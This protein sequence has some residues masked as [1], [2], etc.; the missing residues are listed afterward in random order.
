MTNT[1]RDNENN[2]N[3]TRIIGAVLLIVVLIAAGGVALLTLTGGSGEPSQQAADVAPALENESTVGRTQ[4]R[5]EPSGT[6]ARFA[7][8]EV[9]NGEDVTAVGT[10]NEVGGDFIVDFNTPSESEVGTIVVNARTLETDN[11]FRNRALRSFILQ[12]ANDEYEFIRFEPTA[13][14]GLPDE[15]VEP[16]DALE[17]QITGDLTI[18]ETTNEVTFDASVTVE[19]D[20][21]L[22]G[23]ASTTVLYPDFNL[24]IPNAPGV[25]SVEDEVRLE[26]EF[27]AVE[28]TGE[29]TPEATEASAET[30]PDAPEATE[31]SDA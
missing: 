21:V 16:G 24:T 27:T 20:G 3:W 8:D 23:T 5:I 22:V 25:A 12:S 31:A 9:L 13:L 7:I 2:R 6:T 15:S 26:L 17:F 30:T 4:Y 18:V 11:F 10:T 19:E 14:S 28:V 1:S 29:A